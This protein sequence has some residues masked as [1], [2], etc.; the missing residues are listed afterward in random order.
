MQLLLRTPDLH[1]QAGNP[2]GTPS[3][4]NSPTVAIPAFRYRAVL[5]L[6][7]LLPSLPNMIPRPEVLPSG[8]SSSSVIHSFNLDHV[9]LYGL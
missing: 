1:D 9:F 4:S 7:L 8:V 3:G 6:L 2:P 5:L